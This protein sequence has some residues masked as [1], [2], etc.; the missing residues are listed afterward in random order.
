MKRS[1]DVRVVDWAERGRADVEPLLAEVGPGLYSCPSYPTSENAAAFAY[2]TLD[3]AL[4]FCDPRQIPGLSERESTRLSGPCITARCVHWAGHCNLGAVLAS[5]AGREV[6]GR[7]TKDSAT[8]SC[9]IQNI[10]RWKAENG[11][12]ACRACVDVDYFEF[13]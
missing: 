2:R 6:G 7:L 1:L 10:C 12:A 8:G 9:P 4:I 11:S 3:G 13:A 5:S